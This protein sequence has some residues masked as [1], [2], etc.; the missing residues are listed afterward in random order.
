MPKSS[1]SSCSPF[2]PLPFPLPFLLVSSAR[3][4]SSPPRTR[5]ALPLPVRT[6]VV[7]PVTSGS[8]AFSARVSSNCS[9]SPKRTCFPCLLCSCSVFC[10]CSACRRCSCSH[11]RRCSCCSSLPFLLASTAHLIHLPTPSFDP[12]PILTF[13]EVPSEIILTIFRY[14]SVSSIIRIVAS[15]SHSRFAGPLSPFSSS[16]NFC[17]A[18][19]ALAACFFS[20]LLFFSLCCPPPLILLLT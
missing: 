3:R 1:S 5:L 6:S 12:R 18:V 20:A 9:S 17:S 15:L 14:P 11:R 13:H 16:V 10:P 8:P 4:H 19:F 7:L 2:P